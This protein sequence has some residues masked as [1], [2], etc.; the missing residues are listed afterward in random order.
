MVIYRNLSKVFIILSINLFFLPCIYSQ[1][2]IVIDQV[3]KEYSLVHHLEY[4]ED[5]NKS[6][7]IQDV[8]S[9]QFSNRFKKLDKETLNIGFTKSAYWVRFKIRNNLNQNIKLILEQSYVLLNLIDFYK[10]SGSEMI[11]KQSGQTIPISKWDYNYRKPSF[12]LSERPHEKGIYY[13]RFETGSIMIISLNLYTEKDFYYNID[14][15]QF[16]L[17]IFYGILLIMIVYNL[18]IYLTT[19]DINYLYYICFA[20]SITLLYLI[21]DGIVFQYLP[22]DVGHEIIMRF[23][24]TSYSAVIFGIQF[25]RSFLEIRKKHKILDRVMQGVIIGSSIGLI[26]VLFKITSFMVG[27]IVITGCVVSI[28]AS[29]FSFKGGF[30]PARFFVVG[31]IIFLIGSIC[32]ALANMGYITYNAITIGLMPVGTVIEVVLFSFS[33]ADKI[34]LLKLD[35]EIAQAE[36]IYNLQQANLAKND[37]LANISHEIRTP[38]NGIM[39]MTELVLHNTNPDSEQKEYLEIVMK[40]SRSLMQILN[41]LLDFSKIRKGSLKLELSSFKLQELIN[42]IIDI[43]VPQCN[44]KNLYIQSDI[45]SDVPNELIGDSLRLQQILMNL[46]DNAIKFT[47]NGGILIN[48]KPVLDEEIKNSKVCLYITVKDT[49]IGIPSDKQEKIFE[50]FTQ[51]E[52][53]LHKSYKG[54]GLGLA[55]SQDIVKMMGGIIWLESKP[56]EGSSFHFTAYFELGRKSM[57]M[58]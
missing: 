19:L 20:I 41:D 40:S 22:H 43:Y 12:F 1:D 44:E 14:H 33:L 56:N 39:G 16:L 42:K 29:I 53:S 21:Y 47:K 28:I 26:L 6:W 34:H 31:W 13:M 36:A 3:R 54:I 7:T 35:K 45:S 46:L 49:G 48:V 50:H 23:S 10:I 37:F 57:V 24:M 15:Q 5:K 55:V 25:T 51:A 4:L 38:M 8:S 2:E 9:N 17:G 18:F 58:N 27:I 11:H 52:S 32:L 30:K